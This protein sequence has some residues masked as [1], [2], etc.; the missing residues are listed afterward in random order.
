MF[1]INPKLL[2]LL[3]PQ[4]LPL[5]ILM[6]HLVCSLVLDEVLYFPRLLKSSFD[7][8]GNLAA[9]SVFSGS[10]ISDNNSFTIISHLLCPGHLDN[11]TTSADPHFFFMKKNIEKEKSTQFTSIYLYQR[12]RI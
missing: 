3:R 1:I 2:L 10:R 12:P 8:L 11:L 6:A 4:N 9:G 7:K 5:K